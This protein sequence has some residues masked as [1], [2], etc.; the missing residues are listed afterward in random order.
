MHFTHCKSCGRDLIISDCLSAKGTGEKIVLEEKVNPSVMIIL[1]EYAIP[2]RNRLIGAH[3]VLQQ[4][5]ATIHTGKKV[6]E[7]LSEKI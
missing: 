6:V 4:D 1:E 3:F 2:E 5:N 7:Y